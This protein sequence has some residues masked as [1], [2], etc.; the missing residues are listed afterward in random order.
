MNEPTIAL[1]DDAHGTVREQLAAAWQLHIE[2][3]QEVVAAKWPDDIERI[4]AEAMSGLAARLDAQYSRRAVE[5]RGTAQRELSEKLNQSARRLRDFES[6]WQWGNTLVE[7]TQGFCDRAALFTVEPGGLRLEAARN[8][9]SAMAME[10]VPLATAPAFAHAVESKDTVIATRTR[11]EMSEPIAAL[12]G[13]AEGRRFHLFPVVARERVAAVLYAD[14]E[15][16]PV[17]S[18]ALELLS[19]FAAAVLGSRSPAP[20]R[21]NLINIAAGPEAK[22]IVS[23]WF[24]LSREDQELHLKAQRFA[25]VHVAGIRLHKSEKVKEGRTQ[26]ALYAS[27]KTEIDSGREVFM[28]DFMPVS[29]TMVDYLHLELLRTLANDNAELLGSDYPGPMV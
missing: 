16:R 8:L 13:E 5:L 26:R 12:L 3:I 6:I 22:P 25:R 14:A 24:T 19:T 7:S 15:D 10:N 18:G 20:E 28:R 1:L 27:L 17:E 29:P 11:G 21:S 23:S 4:F 9:T 2:H